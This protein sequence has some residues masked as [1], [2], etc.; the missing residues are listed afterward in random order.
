MAY[1]GPVY[2]DNYTQ[3]TQVRFGGMNHQKSAGDGEWF[4]TMNL[5]S[6]YFP[7]MASREPRIHA[8]DW[9][10]HGNEIV[11]MC[12]GDT[13]YIAL[14]VSSSADTKLFATQFTENRYQINQ[15]NGVSLSPGEKLMAKLGPKMII[16]P[17]KVYYNEN[18]GNVENME[19]DLPLPSLKIFSGTYMGEP[20]TANCIQIVTSREYD[21]SNYFTV[22]QAVHITGLAYAPNNDIRPVI[23]EVDAFPT[24]GSGEIFNVLTLHFYDNT[25]SIPA[26]SEP[27]TYYDTDGSLVSTSGYTDNGVESSSDTPIHITREAPD[28]DIL[29]VHENRLWG[30]KGDTIWASALGDPLNWY[31]FDT[32]D[33]A[34]W[35]LDVLSEGDFTGGCSFL[36]YPVYFKDNHIYKIYGSVPSDFSLAQSADIG[37]APGSGRTL[38]I[39][40]DRLF[41][42]SRV[43][44][45]M[46]TGALPQLI[47]KPAFGDRYMRNGVGGS[48]GVKYRITCDGDNH[49]WHHFVYDTQN[50]CWH[51]ESNPYSYMAWGSGNLYCAGEQY[52]DVLGNLSMQSETDTDM[53]DLWTWSAESAD[54]T[55]SSPRRKWVGAPLEI[56][57]EIENSPGEMHEGHRMLLGAGL[58]VF[59]RFDHDTDTDPLLIGAFFTTDDAA[60]EVLGQDATD[61]TVVN[62]GKRSY[63]CKQIPIRTD[64][65]QII[66]RGIGR[67]WIYSIA[68]QTEQGS[69]YHGKNGR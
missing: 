12:G 54:Y 34:S 41:Y 31:N 6:D 52:I 10:E 32:V 21:Y 44:V 56:R 11:G 58:A 61:Y 33:T 2:P 22:G 46:Y 69:S 7:V 27:V 16:Y 18:T 13:V 25:F 4:Q 68:P 50:G 47:S 14:Q 63:I 55:E 35:S 17:D 9:L 20:A 42:L 51:E 39:A 48:D 3:K 59:I 37:V 23:R 38:A 43:G 36:G 67:V 49:S 62:E 1:P 45:M 8:F 26:G 30:A 60:H 65:Y 64:H 15:V 29:F 53:Q 24:H 19:Q 57:A 66:I 28:L 40:G 5:T